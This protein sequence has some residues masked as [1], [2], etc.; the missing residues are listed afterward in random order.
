MEGHEQL[1]TFELQTFKLI[2]PQRAMRIIYF[3]AW[4]SR[5]TDDFQFR[6]NFSRLWQS[7]L[8]EKGEQ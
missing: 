5:H 6:K 8:L 1:R 4:C 3:L 2:E 7:E